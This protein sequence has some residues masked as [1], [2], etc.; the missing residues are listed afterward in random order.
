MALVFCLLLLDKVFPLAL[1]HT[2]QLFARI[3]VDDSGRPLRAFADDSGVWRYPIRL[4]EVSPLYI[5]ALVN[6]EDQWFWHHPGVN[7]LSLLRAAWQNLSSGKIV[8][9]GST[10]SMQVARLLHPHARSLWGKSQQLLRTLQLEWRLSKSEILT[11]YLN[12]APFGGT[13]EGV[14]AASFHYLNKSATQLSHAE[15]ALLAVLPQA[16]TQLRPDI[17]PDLAEQARNKVLDRLLAH[18]VWSEEVAMDAKQEQVYAFRNQ[19]PKIAPLLARRLLPYSNGQEPIHT[20]INGELQRSL[21]SYLEDFVQTLPNKNSAAILVADNKTGAVKAY[22]G[23]ANFLDSRRFGHVDMIQAKRSP[24][25][26]LKPFLFGM[27]LDESLIHSHSLLAD[28]PR[29]WGNYHPGNFNGSFSGP[30]SAAEALQRSL[31]LPF[32]DLLQRY[33]PRKFNA[34]LRNAGLQLSIPDNNPNLSL[35]L[36]GAGASLE[37]LV[38][39]YMAL[40]RAGGTTTLKYRR[41]ELQATETKRYLLSP[42]S[43]WITRQVL[44]DIKRPGSL[45]TLASM[46]K[47][48][49]LAWKTGTSFGF[50]DSWAIGV[51]NDY[52]I[53]VWVGRPDGTAQPGHSGR[54]TAAPLL[55]TVADFLNPKVEA[56]DQNNYLTEGYQKPTSVKKKTICWPLGTLKTK[57]LELCHREYQAWILDGVIPP[58]WH[59]ADSDAWQSNPLTYQISI[60]TKKRVM[61]GCIDGQ[62]TETKQVALWPKIL[63]P[64]IAFHWKRHGQIPSMDERCDK[65]FSATSSLH[66]MG[67]VDGSKFRKAGGSETNPMVTLQAVGGEGRYHWYINGVRRFSGKSNRIIPFPLEDKGDVQILVIDDGGNIDQISILV[68]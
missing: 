10:L 39:A 2:D 11:L 21:E 36:G 63:E 67:I 28:V 16:P 14:Q 48:S 6:Y 23:S 22:L 55:F 68:I 13:I 54:E 65:G 26:T 12:I 4:D 29:S 24:G 27:S 44:S 41:D 50:R 17:H 53:G 18:Q 32:I 9:G 33:G 34:R 56:L 60:A 57:S 35:I 19:Q 49:T 31:N 1:P 20:T 58:T 47:K 37:H 52:T 51:A 42:G 59:S 46:R 61:A 25:S 40:A 5:E 15:A 64:W 66:I 62:A 38:T 30:V 8:S 43:A 3:V 45:N 7:P